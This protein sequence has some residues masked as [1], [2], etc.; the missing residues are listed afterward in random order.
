MTSNIFVVSGLN[1]AARTP[2][3]IT[4][5][6]LLLTKAFSWIVAI[7]PIIPSYMIVAASMIRLSG[8]RQDSGCDPAPSGMILRILVRLALSPLAYQSIS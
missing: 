7:A 3:M 5:Y 4:C 8:D 2:K 1:L 6:V